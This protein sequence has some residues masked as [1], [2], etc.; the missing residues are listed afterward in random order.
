[1]TTDSV[2]EGII[3]GNPKYFR[4]D[5]SEFTPN[6][7]GQLRVLYKAL[8]PDFQETPGDKFFEG[9]LESGEISKFAIFN[10]MPVGAIISRKENE[11]GGPSSEK[12]GKSSKKDAKKAK[13]NILTIGVLKPYLKL[14]L[15]HL[16]LDNVISFCKSDKRITSIYHY[17]SSSDADSKAIFESRK[18][19]VK[20][21]VKNHFGEG[22]D[23]ILLSLELESDA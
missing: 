5:V 8:V 21:T 1:M 2:D 18:F 23:A 15:E 7:L 14:G 9:V 13:V 6:N 11:D 20:E 16:L 10:D 22:K 3:Q 4:N 19:A 12:G 17:L